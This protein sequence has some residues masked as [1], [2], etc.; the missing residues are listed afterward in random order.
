LPGVT[1]SAEEEGRQLQT[2]LDKI[3]SQIATYRAKSLDAA[4]DAESVRLEVEKLEKRQL[5][6]DLSMDEMEDSTDSTS[7]LGDSTTGG[8][9]STEDDDIGAGRKKK[10]ALKAA[11]RLKAQQ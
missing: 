5:G 3:K 6:L 8:E 9:T 11:R 2:A 7:A 4:H 10:K 1:I